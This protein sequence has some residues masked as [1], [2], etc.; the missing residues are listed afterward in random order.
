MT[1]LSGQWPLRPPP[2]LLAA[3]RPPLGHIFE[4]F[5]T[6]PNHTKINPRVLWGVLQPFFA[7]LKFLINVCVHNTPEKGDP[8]KRGMRWTWPKSNL[9]LLG[10]NGLTLHGVLCTH[11]SIKHFKS[12]KNGCKTP[13]TTLEL[14]LR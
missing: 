3:N 9:S 11:R 1:Q 8:S 7:L 14:I 4:N 12:A 6:A 10:I 13:Q 2:S 5:Q